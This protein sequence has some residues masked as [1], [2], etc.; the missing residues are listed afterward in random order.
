MAII[1]VASSWRN[2]YLPEEYIKNLTHLAAE[3]GF[4]TIVYCRRNRSRNCG[5]NCLTGL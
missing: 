4:K 3:K 5:I 2:K 1:F